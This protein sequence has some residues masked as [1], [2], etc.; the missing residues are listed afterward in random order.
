MWKEIY[1][2]IFYNE[3][4]VNDTD[5]DYLIEKIKNSDN[6]EVK[7]DD[8]ESI[9]NRTTYRFHRSKYIIHKDMYAMNI[10]ETLINSAEEFTT[11][12]FDKN[13][14][15]RSFQLTTKYFDSN[16]SYGLHF[17]DPR[18]FGDYFFVLYLDNCV[19]G[20]LVFPDLNDITILFDKRIEDK[21]EW[22]KGVNSLKAGGYDPLIV[23]TT[24]KV[25]PKRNTAILGKIPYVHYVNK[26]KDNISRTVVNGFPFAK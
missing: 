23:D 2:D 22:N 15:T 6:H 17:E 3:L 19:D 14:I 16:S 9:I 4:A 18:Y 21:D 20:E 7:S 26:I 13:T 8:F 24:F 1:K 5:I 25:Q 11:L 12:K 10:V